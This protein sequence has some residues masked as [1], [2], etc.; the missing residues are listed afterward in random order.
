MRARC[1]TVVVSGLPSLPVDAMWQLFS[2]HY[3]GARRENFDRDLMAKQQALLL[4]SGDELVGFTSQRF[5]EIEGHRV[6]YSGDVIVT[7]SARDIGTAHFFH[8]WARAVWKNCD[9]WCALSAGPRTFRIAHTFYHR[10]TPS[11]NVSE[12][13][14]ERLLRHTFAKYVYG[15]AYQ[16]E[17]GIVQFPH[18]YTL[19]KQEQQIRE[20]YP[21]NEYFHKANSGWHRGDELVSLVSLRPDNWKPIARRMLKWKADCG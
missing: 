14:E 4:W 2:R 18:C 20:E 17:L 13:A 1:E 11:F 16:S 12:T 7:P 15:D 10:V 19:R 21:M 6:I 3:S 8:H 9:W 5:E